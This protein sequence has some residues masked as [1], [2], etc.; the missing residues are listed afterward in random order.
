[1]LCTVRLKSGTD[2]SPGRFLFL[3]LTVCCVGVSL[4]RV[5]EKTPESG[6]LVPT[7]FT[8]VNQLTGVRKSL[9]LFVGTMGVFLSLRLEKQEPTLLREPPLPREERDGDR[10]SCDLERIS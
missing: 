2:G 4:L 1:M 6:S 3:G 8:I 5:G 7:E 9:R 10:K